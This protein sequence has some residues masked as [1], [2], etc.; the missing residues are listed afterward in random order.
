MWRIVR[1]GVPAAVQ[2]AA[3]GRRVRGGRRRW[4][5]ASRRRPLAAQSDRAQHRQLLLHGAVR[6]ELGGRRARRA[7]GRPRRSGAASARA[8]WA[9]LALLAASFMCRVDDRVRRRC[10]SRSCAIFTR[11]AAV[12]AIGATLLLVC[13][14][15]QP[16]DGF[17]A[18]ATGALRGLGDTR[19]P[20][21]VNL[22]GHWVDRPAGRVR[23][24]FPARLGRRGT[25]DGPGARADR[26]SAAC[27]SACGIATAARSLR[28]MTAHERNRREAARVTHRSRA[29]F[30]WRVSAAAPCV[31]SCAACPADRRRRRRPRTPASSSTTST[32]RCCGSASSRQQAGWVALDLHHATTPRR[33]T[34]RANQAYIDAIASSSRRTRRASTTCTVPPDQ[35]RQLNLLKLSLELVTPADPKEAEELTTLAAASKATYGT[36]QVVQGPGEAGH[37]PRHRE[38]HRGPGEVA[39]SERAPRGLGRLAHDLAADAQGLHALRRALEQGREGAGLRR[40]RRD[41]AAEVRHA[42]RRLH[43]GSRSA[44]G[45]GAAALPVAAR[46][47]AHEAAREVRRRRSRR[48]ADS[49]APARQHLGAGLVQRLRSRRAG[50]RRSG[51]LAHE[52]PEAAQDVA[53]STW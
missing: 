6:A 1:L 38:D 22:V 31:S 8:G 11:D 19:T 34:P 17:Q 37:L 49:R 44:L 33:S 27:S 26:S 5:A 53:P 43:E 3:R 14:V 4:P 2:I 42:R 12:L 36:R 18:V 13:A 46:V 29:A 23:A 24:L 32:R 15:F 30:S 21:L 47:R 39:R 20:M 51:L 7:G 41:V 52:D 50:Q 48:R 35:R 45:A 25:V 9:A 28:D 40:H 10:R 16:F